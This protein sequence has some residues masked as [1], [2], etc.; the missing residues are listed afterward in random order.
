MS[1][2]ARRDP[3]R[4][5][6]VVCGGVVPAGVGDRAG[7]G[8]SGPLAQ[9]FARV[10]SV[11][12]R[13]GISKDAIGWESP[14]GYCP[15]C[16]IADGCHDHECEIADALAALS[17]IER[18]VQDTQERIRDLEAGICEALSKPYRLEEIAKRLT[19]PAALSAR[20]KGTE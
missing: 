19:V 13:A 6:V 7:D 9:Q 12:E 16:E 20:E 5:R 11:L 15:S 1:W 10:E 4:G 8:V 2:T 18:H 14:G 3:R 17:V